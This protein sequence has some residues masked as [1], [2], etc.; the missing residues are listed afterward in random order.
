[1]TEKTRSRGA[2]MPPPL[3]VLC[4]LGNPGADLV[5]LLRGQWE[6]ELR[7]GIVELRHGVAAG[8]LTE[9]AVLCGAG[10]AS[11]VLTAVDLEHEEAPARIARDDVGHLRR[12][13]GRREH[14]RSEE[15]RVG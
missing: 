7:S 12:R 9:S 2:P 6:V 14:S 15:R 4:A 13:R 3:V 5:G 1:T 8:G 10:Q 11:G